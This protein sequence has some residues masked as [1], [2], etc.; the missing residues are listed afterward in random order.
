MWLE[1][2]PIICDLQRVLMCGDFNE[3]LHESERAGVRFLP[4]MVAFQDFILECELHDLP[5]QGRD[6]TWH[7]RLSF[8]RI[9]KV[10]ASGDI[11]DRWPPMSISTVD[12]TLSDYLPI[13]F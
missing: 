1:I 13:L 2:T 5:L 11:L 3:V 4:S 6:Y 7:N 12:T 10:L 8:S 9:D